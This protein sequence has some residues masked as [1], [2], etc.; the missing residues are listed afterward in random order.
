[1]RPCQALNPRR[2]LFGL[3]AFSLMTALSVQAHTPSNTDKPVD[4]VIFKNGD[5]LS[6]ALVR[7]DGGNILFKS[8]VVGEVTIPADK[9]QQLRSNGNFV[10]IRKDERIT[11]SSKQP[12]SMTFHDGSITVADLKGRAETVTTKD[13]GHIIDKETYT[14]EVLSNP[15]PFQ[16]WSGSITGGSTVV[17]ATTLAKT[18]TI[19]VNLIR[20]IPA[21][22]YLNRRTRTTFDLL[23]TFNKLTEPVIPQTV[24]PSPPAVT[25]T[26][27]FHTAFEHNRYFTPKVYTLGGVTFD[28]N[29]TQG[30]DL[31]QAYGA[32][33][34]ATL[35]EDEVQQLDLK[36]DLHYM[37]QN[38][39]QFPPPEISTPTQNLIGST[40]AETYRRALPG[41]IALTQSINYTQSW[42]NTH[43]YSFV[44]A[45]G[46]MMPFYHRFSLSVNTL[47][48]YLNDP[49]AGFKNNSFQFVTGV[50]YTLP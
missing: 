35:I 41:K 50:T 12:G 34:G 3:V 29:S 40:F 10:V 31:Q 44:G 6:G 11:R 13:L 38:F 18:Y 27:I 21:V 4:Y 39:V 1:M 25:R 37:R 43:V 36:G 49:A 23:E 30:L 8:E 9:V 20:A 46:L 28:H 48:T 17:S 15:G 22:A 7:F 33:I 2:G 5:K 26:H 42:N 24:P 19:G 45:V 32:G 16:R 14:K 47:N